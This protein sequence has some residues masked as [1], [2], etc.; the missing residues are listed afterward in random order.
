M[1]NGIINFDEM[2]VERRSI[3]E[4]YQNSSNLERNDYLWE[5][6]NKESFA[7]RINQNMSLSV[8]NLAM[9]QQSGKSS[10][11]SIVLDYYYKNMPDFNYR[12]YANTELGLYWTKGY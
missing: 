9:P 12:I 7:S 3:I 5:W 2:E 10:T 11:L 1:S 8:V 6:T 4:L